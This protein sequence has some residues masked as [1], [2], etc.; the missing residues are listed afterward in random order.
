M[1]LK[2]FERITLRPGERK[3]VQF[4]LAPA[5]LT[6]LDLHMLRVVEPGLFDI[7]VGPSSA[8]TTSVPLEV[9]EK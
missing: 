5:M 1:E 6:I 7:M 2:G 4:K 3:T 8:E 9:V